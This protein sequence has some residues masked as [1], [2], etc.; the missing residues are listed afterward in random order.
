MHI[1]V[2]TFRATSHRRNGCT[3]HMDYQNDIRLRHAQLVSCHSDQEFGCCTYL[4]TL[5][6]R[7]SA[8][9]Q[10]VKDLEA[11]LG[12][13]IPDIDG[14]RT[15]KEEREFM[16]SETLVRDYSKSKINLDFSLYFVLSILIYAHRN[17]AV[18]TRG[19]PLKT[20]SKTF[21]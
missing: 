14:E 16:C 15:W 11:Y 2:I 13:E 5:T 19:C 1:D 20:N 18:R 10:K 6:E 9:C 12:G 8:Q 7:L 17:I 4:R 3:G 21:V